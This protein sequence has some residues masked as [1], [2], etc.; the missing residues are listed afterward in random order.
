MINL[1][2][3][4][5][6]N[7]DSLDPKVVENKIFIPLDAGMND[8]SDLILSEALRQLREGAFGRFKGA[9][10]RGI[11]ARSG[12]V[13]KEFLKKRVGFSA[14]YAKWIEYGTDPHYPPLAPILAWVL[15]KR[16]AKN[17]RQ[18]H[19][20]AQKIVWSMG[21]YGTE[22]KPFLRR[23]IALGRKNLKRLIENKFRT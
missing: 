3:R 8:L 12:N 4:I 5:S 16:L 15:R 2:I 20:I 22:P 21:T 10:D 14:P 17:K 18:A 1:V 11:L 9:F 6:V 7:L 13:T 23:A 19:Q